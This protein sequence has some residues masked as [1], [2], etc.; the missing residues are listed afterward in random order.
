MIMAKHSMQPAISD[1]GWLE[2]CDRNIASSS[3]PRL[4]SN[5]ALEHF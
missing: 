1:R 2:K 5:A 3:L 4:V